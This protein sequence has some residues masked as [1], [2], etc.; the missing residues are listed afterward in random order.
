MPESFPASFQQEVKRLGAA[1]E[2][3]SGP[4][5]LLNSVYSTGEMGLAIK[6]QALIVDT[7]QGLIVITGCAHPNV[8]DIAERAQTYLGKKIYLLMGGFHLGGSSDVKIR[9]IIKRLKVLGVKKVAPSHCTGGN[10]I[11][12]FR[13]EWTDDFIEGGLGAIIEVSRK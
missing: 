12:M 13:D 2:T 6:E 3:V 11:R 9:A 7:P 5:P 8:A 1:T 10:A 4:R